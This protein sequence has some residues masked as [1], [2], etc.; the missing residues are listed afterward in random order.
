M[1]YKTNVQKLFAYL[2]MFLQIFAN[3]KKTKFNI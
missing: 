3:N 1:Y 2:Q